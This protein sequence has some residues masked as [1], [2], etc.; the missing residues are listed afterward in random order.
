M[1]VIVTVIVAVTVI[2]DVIVTA[3]GCKVVL[4]EEK[5]RV[6]TLRG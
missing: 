5:L 1:I 6:R 2:V 3:R 4:R